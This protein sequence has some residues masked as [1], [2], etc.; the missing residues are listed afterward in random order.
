MDRETHAHNTPTSCRSLSCSFQL[1]HFAAGCCDGC[2]RKC[3]SKGMVG[4]CFAGPQKAS[5]WASSHQVPEMAISI[6]TSKTTSPRSNYHGLLI[7]YFCVCKMPAA[8]LF[9]RWLK[10][11]PYLL[12]TA[13]SAARECPFLAVTENSYY[14]Y[15]SRL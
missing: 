11:C 9:V 15:R 2:R 1:L 7:S 3:I 13:S 8:D 4:A 5:C 14:L 10:I 6:H 12:R